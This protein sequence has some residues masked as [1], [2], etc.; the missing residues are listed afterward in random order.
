ME[1]LILIPALLLAFLTLRGWPVQLDFWLRTFVALASLAAAFGLM[2]RLAPTPHAPHFQHRQKPSRLD[3]VAGGSAIT[4]SLVVLYLLFVFGPTTA[5]RWSY[6][7]VRTDE[8]QLEAGEEGEIDWDAAEAGQMQF[9]SGDVHTEVRTTFDPSG[10][11]VPT[12]ANLTLKDKPEVR[13][14]MK[15]S[16]DAERLANSG[17]VYISAF[18]HDFFDGDRWTTQAVTDSQTVSPNR[19]GLIPLHAPNSAPSY[20]YSI[21]HGRHFDRLNTVN[22]LQGGLTVQLPE[23]TRISPGTW[24]LPI[25][26]PQVKHYQYEASSS[27]LRLEDLVSNGRSIAPGETEAVYRAPTSHPGLQAQ[28]QSLS[29]QFDG[30]A[31]LSERLVQLQEWLRNTY[32]Y[33][34]LV[35]YPDNGKCALENFL[36]NPETGKGFCVHFASASALLTRELGVPSRICFGWT[37]GRHYQKHDQFV[38]LSKHGHAWTEIHL[39]DYGWV[40]FDTT[41]TP[42]RPQAMTTTPG[43]NPPALKEF[44]HNEGE[45]NGR[46]IGI[47]LPSSS[48]WVFIALGIGLTILVFLRAFQRGRSSRGTMQGLSAHSSPTPGYLMLFHQAC[49]RLGHPMPTG[50]TL[51]QHLQSLQNEEIPIQFADDLLSYHY[52][53]TYRNVSRDPQTEKRLSNTIKSW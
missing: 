30:T 7:L 28:I 5:T 2:S 29:M 35:N 6:K 46:R 50:R 21:L 34:L 39:Q 41:P 11:A 10:A 51:A 20:E 49:A 25:L 52:D 12:S 44:L 19:D 38:F 14:E 8:V 26:S 3:R 43:E 31:S 47:A 32:S 42:S 37:G 1:R 9:F 48:V 4:L 15:T 53:I 27:P 13:L 22:L 17:P 18:A 33:S 40:V 23:V 36:G 45:G 24:L 16:K